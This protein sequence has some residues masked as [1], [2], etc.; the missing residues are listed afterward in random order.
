VRFDYVSDFSRAGEWRVEGDRVTMSSP[1]PMR[2]GTRL[3]KV[4]RLAERLATAS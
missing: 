2:L 4:A 1:G 3:R